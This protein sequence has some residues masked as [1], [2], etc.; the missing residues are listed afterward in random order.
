[1]PNNSSTVIDA[2]SGTEIA[3]ISMTEDAVTR[4]IQ[5]VSVD[6]RQ[7]SPPRRY[8]ITLGASGGIT[9]ITAAQA[10]LGGIMAG[11]STVW[12]KQIQLI[13]YNTTAGII[14]PVAVKRCT[15]LAAGT[16]ITAADVPE[17]FT[18][19]AVSDAVLRYGT[20]T[21]SAK[22]AHRLMLLMPQGTLGAVNAGGVSQTWMANSLDDNIVLLSGEALV[23]DADIAGDTDN[24]YLINLS[25]EEV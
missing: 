18:A 5:R 22:A 23:F 20:V 19:G 11:T 9:A 24:R 8:S 4:H 1:M 3:T 2:A 15:T 16:L 17:H 25:W 14:V 6:Q 10:N 13:Q 7:G 21:V 12:I